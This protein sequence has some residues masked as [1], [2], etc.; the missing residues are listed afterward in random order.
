MGRRTTWL[1]AAL[2]ARALVNTPVV[3][4]FAEH[5]DMCECPEMCEHAEVCRAY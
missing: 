5:M 4:C 2:R 1:V 3:G